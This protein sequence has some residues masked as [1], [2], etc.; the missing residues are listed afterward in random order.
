MCYDVGVLALCFMKVGVLV[1]VYVC[2]NKYGDDSRV[3]FCY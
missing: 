2:V 1:L 3:L